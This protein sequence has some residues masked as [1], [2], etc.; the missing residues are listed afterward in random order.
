MIY[1]ALRRHSMHAEDRGDIAETEFEYSNIRSLT[2][3]GGAS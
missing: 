3:S 2:S 1:T